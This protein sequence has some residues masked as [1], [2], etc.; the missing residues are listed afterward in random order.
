MRKPLTRKAGGT[1]VKIDPS[2]MKI[3]V[4]CANGAMSVIGDKLFTKWGGSDLN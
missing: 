2:G 3:G 4:D 1:D